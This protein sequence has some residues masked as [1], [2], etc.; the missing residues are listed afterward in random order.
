[1]NSLGFPKTRAFVWKKDRLLLLDQRALPQ[2][3]LWKTCRRWPQVAKGISDMAVRGAPAIGCVAAYGLVLAAREKKF[4]STDEQKRTLE[5]A[6][7]GL[8]QARPTAVNLR[9][10]LERMRLC[11]TSFPAVSGGEPMD[12]THVGRTP[13][14]WRPRPK[15]AGD[16]VKRLA[17]ALEAEAVK[18]EEEDRQS[19]RRIG[20]N[21]AALLAFD[22]VVLTH[23]NTGSLATAGLGTAFGVFWTA[24]RGNKIRKVIAC[25]TRPYLQGARLTAWE[26]QQEKI[27][28]ELITDSM[29]A[30]FMKT[31]KI[32]AVIVGADRIASNGD[33][34][35]K[36][37]TYSLA[38]LA[39]HHEIPFYV[40][41]PVSTVDL[42]TA[43]GKDIPIEERS[44][45]EVTWVQGKS[46][47]PKNTIARHPAFD[48]TPAELIA[49][50]ITDQGVVKPPYSTALRGL[51][52]SQPALI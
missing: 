34:A 25:E 6:F 7:D 9:W 37:G 18:I 16:D 3:L 4:R 35:N 38:V 51:F 45:A 13:D 48:V 40:A 44:A 22:S 46:I 8:L 29:A 24:H 50:I 32:D 21:G 10:A 31:E 49:A 39:A 47:A 5:H 28:F 15:T 27:P 52:E 36:I 23:C 41:A 19:N 11:Y 1:M 42:S 14:V 26:L 43:T 17:R 33:T 20:Q 2:R 30:H 12:P